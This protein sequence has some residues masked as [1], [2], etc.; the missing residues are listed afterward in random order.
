MAQGK[1]VKIDRVAC[2]G[3]GSCVIA[4]EGAF[5]IDDEGKAVLTGPVDQFDPE[6]L[7]AGARSCPFVAIETVE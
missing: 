6:K 5:E 2:Q 3:V 1:E 7:I 4:S